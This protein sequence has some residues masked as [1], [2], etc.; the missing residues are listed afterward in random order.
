MRN[1]QRSSS[2]LLIVAGIIISIFLFYTLTLRQ[3]H[4]WFG[5]FSLYIIHA[6]NI[7]NA[8]PYSDTGYILNPRT[9]WLSPPAY[10]PVLPVLLTPV[11]KLFGIDLHLIKIYL[12]LFFCLTLVVL[13][14]LLLYKID[15][16]THRIL[17]VL[18]TGMSPWFF[19][20]K[21]IIVSEF[22]F[23]FFIYCFL[24]LTEKYLARKETSVKQQWIYGIAIGILA[25]LAYGCRSIG[26]V[27][28]PV[29]VLAVILYQRKLPIGVIISTIVFA[30]GYYMQNILLDTDAHYANLASNVNIE[31]E[32]APSGNTGNPVLSKLDFYFST[33]Q[34][35]IVY[36][37][38]ILS[39]HWHNNFSFIVRMM[40]YLIT[41]IL[42]LIG[43]ITCLK[44]KNITEIF[45]ASYTGILLIVPFLQQNRY[46]L[47]IIPLYIM[48]IMKGLDS[49][50][51]KKIRIPTTV[52]SSTVVFLMGI[53][54]VGAYTDMEYRKYDHGV[55]ARTTKQVFDF[56]SE[57]TNEDSIFL[58][59]K[60]RVL[61]LY[62]KRRAYADY[63]APDTLWKNLLKMKA[64][65]ILLAN[66][67]SAAKNN[68][69]LGSPKKYYEM[70]KIYREQLS[71]VYGNKHFMLYKIQGP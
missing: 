20:W 59:I 66:N 41:S 19:E 45:V 43:Y 10:P 51:L 58:F 42:M 47:P 23:I 52:I 48:Y 35:N 56:I 31:A 71:L 17:V 7:A 26:V 3:G 4:N 39:A 24:F 55:E 6:I 11:V 33:F 8:V 5:D 25:Y 57:S 34:H 18:F 2:E 49:E 68:N 44:K 62:T 36:Y 61:A 63:G 13:Y 38:K 67:D 65:Y 21:D 9:A 12:V 70:I 29:F 69:V 22:A 27:L 64:D 1:Y 40:V 53:S 15:N 60:P 30:I 16:P 28:I 50:I 37:F 54:Y 14:R 46:L 32:S